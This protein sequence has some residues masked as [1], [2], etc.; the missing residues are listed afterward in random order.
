MA[1]KVINLRAAR[2]RKARDL[3]ADQAAENRAR[4][5]RTKTQKS[6]DRRDGEKAERHLDGHLV[7]RPTEN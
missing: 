3:E 5:G 2:K 6:Q 4:F 7:D 1:T